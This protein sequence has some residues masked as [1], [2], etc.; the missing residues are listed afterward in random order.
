MSKWSRALLSYATSPICPYFC[1][2]EKGSSSCKVR[3]ACTD[4]DYFY[5]HTACDANGEV[6]NMVLEP[7][8]PQIA[9]LSA[10]WALPHLELQRSV[11]LAREK[12]PQTSMGTPGPGAGGVRWWG[13][14]ARWP[15]SSS[16]QKLFLPICSTAYSH[17]LC[18]KKP[19]SFLLL[20]FFHWLGPSGPFLPVHAHLLP[21]GT[22]QT[23]PLG[24]AFVCW[25]REFIPTSGLTGE[26]ADC[27]C[28]FLLSPRLSASE[29]LSFVVGITSESAGMI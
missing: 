11:E 14:K 18:C 17:M 22:H 13:G 4:K 23:C 27:L 29:R 28:W 20:G 21:C 6:G 19:L 26:W 25:Q 15:L 12:T 8:C 24:T 1:N 9:P 2:L 5:T 16:G 3:P 7:L 10:P